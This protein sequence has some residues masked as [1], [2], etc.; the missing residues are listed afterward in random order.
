MQLSLINY[1]SFHQKLR[2]VCNPDAAP[3]DKH[4]NGN[5]RLPP[6]KYQ[7]AID[8]VTFPFN[9]DRYIVPAFQTTRTLTLFPEFF[10]TTPRI[11]FPKT[12]ALVS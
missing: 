10:L 7:K 9:P 6:E 12:L 2:D 4:A 1:E 5:K 3:M 8:A 11:F